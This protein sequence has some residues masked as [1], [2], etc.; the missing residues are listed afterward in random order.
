[1]SVETAHVINPSA[2]EAG[3][4]LAWSMISPARLNVVSPL[5]ACGVL[6]ACPVLVSTGRS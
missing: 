4:L 5:C 1:M 2:E 6:G 3:S